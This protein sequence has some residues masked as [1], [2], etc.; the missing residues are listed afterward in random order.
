MHERRK[1][2]E[3]CSSVWKE[4]KFSLDRASSYE[5]ISS[6]EIKQNFLSFWLFFSVC[7]C[8]RVC[9]P[10]PCETKCSFVKKKWIGGCCAWSSQMEFF[11]F[12]S[13]PCFSRGKFFVF[14]PRRKKNLNALD[15]ERE[16]KVFF[17]LV[18]LKNVYRNQLGWGLLSGKR[19]S[20]VNIS[21]WGGFLET[22]QFR[23][24]KRRLGLCSPSPMFPSLPLAR[25][26]DFNEHR[27]RHASRNPR[28]S[29]IYEHVTCP[30]QNFSINGYFCGSH[31]G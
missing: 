13:S 15:E 30:K 31:H 22:F 21:R 16:K 17:S 9:T 28:K 5:K 18:R 4:E 14:K 26:H 8:A 10:P 19:P 2:A 11:F 3:K 27:W 24:G 6:D 29:E 12:S 23:R 20:D 1:K 7:E 25:F